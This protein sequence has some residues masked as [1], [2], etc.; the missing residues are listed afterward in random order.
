MEENDMKRLL[1]CIALIPGVVDAVE[2]QPVASDAEFVP[3]LASTR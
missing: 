3:F 1:L 2:R